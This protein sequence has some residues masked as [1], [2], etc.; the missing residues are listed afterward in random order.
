MVDKLL[1]NNIGIIT[2]PS[3]AI[4]MRQLRPIK[5][6]THNSIARVL[7]MLEA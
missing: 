6:Y 1:K 3:A 2:C 5:T 7:E 4:S